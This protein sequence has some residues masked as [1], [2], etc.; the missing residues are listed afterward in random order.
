VA[1]SQRPTLLALRALG[2][3][4]FLTGIP[5]LRALRSARADWELVLATSAALRP[6]VELAGGVDRVLP[7][8]GLG[9][10]LAWAAPGPELAVN[11]HGRGPESSRLLSALG[12]G[13]LVAFDCPEASVA[14]PAW[15]PDEHEV[16]RWCRLLEEALDVRT[17]PSD[18]GLRRPQVASPVEGAVVIHPGAAFPSRRWP[19]ERFAAVAAAAAAWGLPVAVTGSS[20]ERQ[21]AQS[22][23]AQAGVPKTAVLAGRTSLLEL[24]ALVSSARLVVSGDTGVAHLAT[25]YGTASVVLFGPISPYLWGPPRGS[26]PHRALWHDGPQGDPWGRQVDPGLLEITVAEVVAAAEQLLSVESG[27]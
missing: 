18:L 13:Q 26:G 2:L 4:D 12:P 7:T 27:R 24:A 16:S 8:E 3:G 11:L 5:A 6:L 21:L 9:R 19:T 15:R 17:D 22:V 20:A 14:G 1:L 25:A 10:P 23:A